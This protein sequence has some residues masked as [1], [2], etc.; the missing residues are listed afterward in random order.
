M[1]TEQANHANT[2][3]PGP[4]RS[5]RA[6]SAG[7]LQ[8]RS[9]PLPIWFA[10]L[11]ACNCCAISEGE[12]HPIHWI[13]EADRALYR[14]SGFHSEWIEALHV[15]LHRGDTISVRW[16]PGDTAYTIEVLNSLD[17]VA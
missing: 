11:V 12:E 14:N 2:A 1:T 15:R 3:A 17:C 7:G 4:A 16:L 13:C 9:A 6:R 8:S 5:T 10:A